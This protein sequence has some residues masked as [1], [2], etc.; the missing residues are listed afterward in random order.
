MAW[1][2]DTCVLIDVLEDDPEFGHLSA[3]TVES[4]AAEGLTVC[5]VTYAELAPAF[6]GDRALQDEFLAG[7]GVD[8][9]QDWTWEDTL[10]ANGAWNAHI[11]RKRS[12]SVPKR[13][14]ADVLIG[15]FAS[16]HQGLITR[17]RRDFETTFPDLALRDPLT[18]SSDA[19]APSRTDKGE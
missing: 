6:K 9:R 11:Q 2:V 17:N 10:Q 18:T 1:V 15:A 3:L 4:C 7:V 13:P 5:P 14:L 12:G 16:R 8:F 19:V